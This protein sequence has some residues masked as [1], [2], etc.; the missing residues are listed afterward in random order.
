[1]GRERENPKGTA[2]QQRGSVLLHS[3]MFPAKACSKSS[4]PKLRVGGEYLVTPSVDVTFTRPHTF[5]DLKQTDPDIVFVGTA[6]PSHL[7]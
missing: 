6:S 5:H 1:M 2:L 3:C 4:V 7:H